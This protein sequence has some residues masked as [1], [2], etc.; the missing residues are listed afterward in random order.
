[1]K[2]Q[3]LKLS[4]LKPAEYNPR[5]KLTPSDE[6]YKMLKASVQNFG[7]V[8]PIIVNVRTMTVIGGHQRLEILKEL[9][10]EEVECV[11]LD[12]DKETEKRLNL[13]LNK[14]S[15]YWDNDK[16]EELFNELNLSEEELFAT[17]FT[18]SE[19]DNLS[20]DFISDL[21]EDEYVTANKQLDQFSI[22]FNI[23]KEYE[24]KFSKYI[25]ANTKEPLIDLMIKEVEGVE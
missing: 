5:K 11:V 2:I 8:D 9:K 7:Y 4:E 24:K 3:K 21:L 16:L 13:S 15:G 10:F 1:M 18:K 12:L 6:A 14:N 25:K 22:T 19:V 20:T 17:G 23:S